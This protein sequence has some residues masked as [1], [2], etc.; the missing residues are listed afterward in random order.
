MV[1]HGVSVGTPE[2]SKIL[3]IAIKGKGLEQAVFSIIELGFLSTVLRFIEPDNATGITR[4]FI[5][6]VLLYLEAL[7][8]ID[9]FVTDVFVAVFLYLKGS[10]IL[11]GEL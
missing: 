4:V 9:R 1:N 8:T 5:C 7:F 6:R 10:E 3:L 11:V 2:F